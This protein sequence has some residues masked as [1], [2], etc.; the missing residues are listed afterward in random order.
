MCHH[1]LFFK[2]V[3][4]GLNLGP[5]T[6]KASSLLN[7]PSA[8]SRTP[9]VRQDL[10]DTH[11]C[12]LKL[13]IPWLDCTHIVLPTSPQSLL[14]HGLHSTKQPETWSHL[15]VTTSLQ[16]LVLFSVPV[17]GIMYWVTSLGWLLLRS[18]CTVF[19]RFINAVMSQCVLRA[20]QLLALWIFYVS[21][22]AFY[23]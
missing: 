12:L 11:F 1:T 15:P 10:Y 3:F 16:A 8:Q 14:G 17:D 2:H 13:L 7:E 22:Y 5:H 20:G 21:Y 23:R 9:L 18:V 4:L 6:C 19:S